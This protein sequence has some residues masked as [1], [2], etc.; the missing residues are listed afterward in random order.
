M[1]I[2]IEVFYPEPHIFAYN[3]LTHTVYNMTAKKPV[4]KSVFYCESDGCYFYK[5]N[6]AHVSVSRIEQWLKEKTGIDY[7]IDYVRIEDEQKTYIPKGRG[8]Y[9]QQIDSLPED[10][11]PLLS[12]NNAI[13]PN[14]FFNI[15]DDTI[16]EK[17]DDGTI[18]KHMYRVYI[19]NYNP[20]FIMKFNDKKISLTL[21]S[22]RERVKCY[23]IENN[24]TLFVKYKYIIGHYNYPY[25]CNTWSN[26]NTNCF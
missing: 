10:L 3:I 2:A 21:K 11:V 16:I 19:G 5:M 6:G 4:P 24:P 12:R 9:R 1:S 22:I 14:Y 13:I 17:C 15:I 25:R 7:T 18:Y 20:Q 26:S 23:I 8:K